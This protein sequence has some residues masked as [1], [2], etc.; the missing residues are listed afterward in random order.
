M[1]NLVPSTVE[2]YIPSETDSIIETS[3]CDS[4][5]TGTGA[6]KSTDT[7]GIAIHCTPKS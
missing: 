7:N 5:P 6:H 1:Q 2:N 4:Y 3:V